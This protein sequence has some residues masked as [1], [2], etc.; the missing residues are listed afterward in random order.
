MSTLELL[1]TL[2]QLGLPRQTYCDSFYPKKA[3]VP[4]GTR[5]YVGLIYRLKGGEGL[6]TLEECQ[7][8]ETHISCSSEAR[9]LAAP[10]SGWEYASTPSSV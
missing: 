10:C 1:S 4:D 9:R 6:D 2:E 8:S 5:E 7:G 3:D